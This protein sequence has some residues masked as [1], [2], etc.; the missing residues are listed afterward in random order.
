MIT[1][2]LAR[3]YLEASLMYVEFCRVSESLMA[4]ACYLVAVR[5]RKVGDWV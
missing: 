4:L 1:L 5:A 3:Y 2:T